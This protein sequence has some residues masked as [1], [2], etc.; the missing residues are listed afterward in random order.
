[1]TAS[2]AICP[3]HNH[4]GRKDVTGAFL[5]EARAFADLHGAELRQFDN[6]AAKWR[7]RREVEAILDAAPLK[8]THVAIFCHGYRRG[9]QTGHTTFS[10]NR[11]AAAIARNATASA[12]VTLYACDTARDGDKQRNDDTKPGPGGEGGFADKLRDGLLAHGMR[13]GHIDAHPVTA[14]ATK[15][16]YVRRFYIDPEA[17]DLGGDWLVAPGSTLWQAWRRKLRQ[18]RRFRLSFPLMSTEAVRGA[19]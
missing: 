16:P 15:A 19:V 18:D 9:L 2:I 17:Q 1:M 3:T 12:S 8:L 10:V 13:G 7:R 6:R 14:H 5:P 11:L 4:R